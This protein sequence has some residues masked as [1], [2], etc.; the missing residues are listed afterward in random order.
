MALIK[1]PMLLFCHRP[2][3]A[4]AVIPLHWL[5]LCLRSQ[6]MC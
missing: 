1:Q 5:L 2:D 3:P 6:V 4:H